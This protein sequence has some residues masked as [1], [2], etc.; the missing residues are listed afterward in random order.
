MPKVI[1][2]HLRKSSVI[3]GFQFEPHASGVIS[4]DLDDAVAA[5][6]LTIPGYVSED[7]ASTAVVDTAKPA[8]AESG[9]FLKSSFQDTQAESSGKLLDASPGF[10]KEKDPVDPEN[11][12]EKSE[13]PAPKAAAKQKK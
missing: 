3:N 6:F 5:K 10:E 11:D 4:E 8:A 1:C 2:K 13:K 12:A 9:N 7:G